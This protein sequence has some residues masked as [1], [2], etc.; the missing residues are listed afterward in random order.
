VIK[1]KTSALLL[2]TEHIDALAFFSVALKYSF[3]IRF[4]LLNAWWRASF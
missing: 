2:I 3:I 4:L 1:F